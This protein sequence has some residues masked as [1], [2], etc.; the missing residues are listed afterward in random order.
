MAGLPRGHGRAGFGGQQAADGAINARCGIHEFP[1]VGV[2][3]LA[4]ELGGRVL[5]DDFAVFHHQDA[6]AIL[7]GKTEIMGDQ[8][9][10]HLTVADEAGDQ[11][12]D[13]F[14]GGDIQAGGGFIGDQEARVTGKR[15]GD[16]DALTHAAG[17]FERIGVVAGFGIADPHI[18]HG[19][20]GFGAGIGAG[21][22]GVA[23]QDIFDLLANLADRV[24]GG[25]RVLEDHGDFAAADIRH[26]VV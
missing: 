23:D 24:E 11:I 19:L 14:L 12:H 7:G 4:E 2:L 5:F 26:G 16:D 3:R 17:E 18:V 13:D 15:D 21:G 6:A 9:G 1:C 22:A 25:A 20:D 8:D 10:A